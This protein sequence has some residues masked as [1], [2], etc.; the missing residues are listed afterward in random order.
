MTR[1]HYPEYRP[2]QAA[3][4]AEGSLEPVGSEVVVSEQRVRS[5][6]PDGSMGAVPLPRSVPTNGRTNS[7]EPFSF[8]ST[9]E[10]RTMPTWLRKGRERV[11]AQLAISQ[12]PQP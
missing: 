10:L 12:T 11:L 9:P 2:E 4:P 1:E 7:S 6:H 8:G 5:S 3:A